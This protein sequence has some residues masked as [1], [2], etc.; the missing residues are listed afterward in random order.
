MPER[1][2]DLIV[3]GATSFVGEILCRYLAKRIGFGGPVSWAIAGRSSKKLEA[4]RDSLGKDAASLK[5]FLADSDDEAALSTMC[6]STRVVVSTVGP[7]ALYGE[8]LIRAC[9]GA[10]T[11]YCDITGEV[12]WIR[13]MIDAYEA[14]AAR[15]GSRLVHCCGFD[16][17]PSDLGVYF[18]QRESIRSGKGPCTQIQMRVKGARGGFSGGTVA[19]LVNVVKETLQ[20]SELRRKISNPFFLCPPSSEPRP[21]QPKNNGPK[22]DEASGGWIAPFIM[23]GI[24]I[25]IV[26]RSNALADYPWGRGF[27]YDEATST[28]KGLSGRVV[29]YALSLAMGAFMAAL[30]VSPLRRFLE[31]FILPKPGE[32]PSPEVQEKGFFDLRF[33]GTRADGSRMTVKVTG[34]RDPGYGATAKMMGEAALCL[35]QDVPRE[36]VPGGFWTPSTAMGDLLI[37]R[38]SANAGMSFGVIDRKVDGRR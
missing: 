37:E 34:D 6:M 14:D 12:Q 33:H 9:V 32:G 25:K 31:R 10:G 5:I 15:S 17:I 30:A 8:K 11:D 1:Q 7:Y 24:N 13:R 28:G 35:A 3:Y 19:S 36:N 26:H 23:A 38:M 29:A 18:L 21:R 27:L 20:D 16:S 2:H 22:Y 4:L